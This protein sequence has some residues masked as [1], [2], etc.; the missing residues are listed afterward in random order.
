MPITED[1][2]T[3]AQAAEILGV[4]VRWVRKMCSEGRLGK[5]FGHGYIINRGELAT[6]RRQ[7]RGRPEEPDV[8]LWASGRC[9]LVI[10][11]TDAEAAEK[12]KALPIEVSEVD[13]YRIILRKQR[14][15]RP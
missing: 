10:A 9:E 2:L 4:S 12:L 1:D 3:V 7:R 11:E 15:S 13:G 5:R 8:R 14:R 6:L